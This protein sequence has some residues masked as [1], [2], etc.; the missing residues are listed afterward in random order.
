MATQKLLITDSTVARLPHATNERGY[1][2]RDR[3]VPG[4]HVRVGRN[5]KTYRLQMD[6]RINGERVTRSFSLGKHPHTKADVARA[7]AL[8]NIR[9][10]ARDEPLTGPTDRGAVTFREAWRSY[11][12]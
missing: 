11:E 9:R 12:A 8:D 3:K 1:I 6:V 10:R 2:A 5:T 7:E 4:F